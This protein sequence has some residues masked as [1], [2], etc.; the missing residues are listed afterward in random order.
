MR[1]NRKTVVLQ[2]P[3]ALRTQ[4]LSAADQGAVGLQFTTLPLLAARLAGGFLRPA[5]TQDLEAALQTAL[6]KGGFAELAPLCAL[7]GMPRAAART[8]RRIWD[9]DVDLGTLHA[10]RLAELALLERRVRES[11]PRDVRLPR[12]LRELALSRLRHAESVLGELVIDRLLSIPLLWRPLIRALNELIPVRWLEPGTAD[13][14]WFTGTIIPA[15]TRTPVP[16][17]VVSCAN[18]RSEV[19]ESLRWA[20]Q[21]LASGKVR[22]QEIAICAAATDEWDEHLLTLAQSADLP[23]HLS[24]GLPALSTREGQACAALADVLLNGLSQD[25]LRRLFVHAIGQSRLLQ[26]LRRDWAVGINSDAGLFHVEHWRRAL[27][28]AAPRRAVDSNVPTIVEPALELLSRGIAVA[29]EA[30][31]ALLSSSAQI[32]WQRAL[33]SAPAE[34]IGLSLQA[35]RVSDASEAAASIVWCPA[36][37]LVGA[38]R[39]YVWLLGL[40]SG[41][42]PRRP[43]EDPLLPEHVLSKHRLDPDP[44]GDQERRAFDLIRAQASGACVISRSRRS[45]QGGLL[46]VS[47][48]LAP[49]G[50]AKPRNRGDIPPHAFSETDRLLARPQDAAASPRIHSAMGCWSDWAAAK[51][52]VHDGQVRAQHPIIEAA[53]R[54]PQSATSLR[55]LLRNPLAFIWRYGLGW[56]APALIEEPLSIDARAWGELVHELLRRTV[57]RLE[58]DPGY[59]RADATTLRNA[60]SAA[61]VEVRDEWPL[62]RPVPPPLLWQ[63]TLAH[64]E[65]LAFRALRV[66]ETFAAGTRCW[67][68]VPFGMSEAEPGDW[69]WNTTATV[70]LPDTSA[71]LRGSIDRLDLNAGASARVTDYKT[72]A[73]PANAEQIVVSGGASLQRVIYAIAAKQLLPNVRRIIARLYY[74]GEATPRSRELPNVAQAVQ[75]VSGYVQQAWI[76]LEEGR[77]LPG[78]AQDEHD[79]Y[80]IALPADLQKYLRVKRVSLRR[81]FGAYGRIW[82]AP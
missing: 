68:E 26:D 8:L 41:T 65:Q 33:R 40:T 58:P 77:G 57:N 17:L 2:G 30:G 48:L 53:L 37:H 51:I 72:G 10:P 49:L 16:P 29:A 1:A 18:P 67:T 19:I 25:R 15:P 61:V 24:S 13:T 82:E 12:D 50:R 54:R 34:A 7:P 75:E 28:K 35:L 20:R 52:T 36:A 45:A 43:R 39:P 6:K 63:Y 70:R 14:E 66:D 4:R 42:W 23:M 55:R 73:E 81:A 5:H 32:V 71:T 27:A 59:T 38:P 78:L 21:L 46:P 22:P 11:L 47:P 60:L 64:A 3:L 9:A 56:Q 31:E 74:L 44:I 80:R 62:E 76:L 79:E 69:P